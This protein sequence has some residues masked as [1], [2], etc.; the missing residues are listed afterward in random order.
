MLKLFAVSVLSALVLV[1][2][3]R[4]DASPIQ[5][6]GLTAG[7]GASASV[8]DYSLVGDVFS[9]DLTN[10]STSGFVTNIGIFIGD[11]VKETSFTTT[12]PFAYTVVDD[13]NVAPPFV[14]LVR[15]G[16]FFLSGNSQTVGINPTV[17]EDFTFDLTLDNG[18]PLSGVTADE[19][20]N[21][22]VVRVRG[23]SGP[24][25]T[26]LAASSVIPEPT[27]LLLMGTGLVAIRRIR[28]RSGK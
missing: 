17:T 21:G 8:S 23:I 18:L 4:A 10:T 28:R 11:V 19:L 16:D 14:G 1:G 20:A 27:S 13:G 12:S 9:F 3:S 6:N 5:L 22:L 2:S 25:Q 15:A 26:D 7:S 24:I